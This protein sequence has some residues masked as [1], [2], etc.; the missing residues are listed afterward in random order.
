MVAQLDTLT[1][2]S[3]CRLRL[4]LDSFYKRNIGWT[5]VLY[6]LEDC[7]QDCMPRILC[8][9][10]NASRYY[11]RQHI[12]HFAGRTDIM[13]KR[14]GSGRCSF[15]TFHDM[16]NRWSFPSYAGVDLHHEPVH[17]ADRTV[18]DTSAVICTQPARE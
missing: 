3:S 2:N 16:G 17:C 8:D 14:W 5:T 1:S 12:R 13:D 6:I 9:L 11:T 18:L 4:D 15:R 10:G 7:I